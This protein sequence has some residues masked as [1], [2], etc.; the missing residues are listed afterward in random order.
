MTK[1]IYI[2]IFTCL[3][4]VLP[5]S[6]FA[7]ATD[8]WK[9]YMAYSN[10]Q[11]IEKGGNMLYVLASNDLYSYNEKD[12]SIQTFDKVNGLNDTDIEFIAWNN[13]A[14]CL[15]IA[16]SDQN[17]DLLT[18]KGE[19][20]SLSD[21][22]RKTM[23]ANKKIN[24][25][26]IEGQYCYVSTGFGILKINVSKAE[27]SDTYNLGFNVNYTY[28][29]GNYI[30]AASNEQGLFRALLSDN[31]LDRNNWQW[32]G[33]YVAQNK[34]I[35]P[36]LLEKV[37]GLQPGGPKYNRF[38]FMQYLNNRLY[39]TGGAFEPGAIG[40]NQPGT[41][42]VLK[43]G[44]WDI[45]QDELDKITGYYYH[46]MNCLAVDPKNPEHVFA[47]GRAGL[48]EFLNGKLK[49]YFNKDNSLLRPSV[50]KGI[51]LGNDYVVI[52][53][54]VFDRKNN[55]WILNSGTKTTSLLKLSP[56]GTMT[57]YSKPQLMN[58]GLSLHVM[59]RPI[60]DSRG[61]IW[62][63]NSHYEAPGLFC[64]N[65][66]TDK[67]NVY[68]NFKNQ[69]GS[70]IMVIQ[71]R[72]V[73]EDAYQNIW[74]GTN[75]G[76]L[77]LTTEQMK[78]P[79][80][81]IFEQIKIPRNDGTN[82]ADY[83]LAGVDISC[84][85]IDGGGRKWFGTNGNGV[86]LISADNMKQVQH[87]LSDNSKLISN[88]I[89]SI[90]INDKTGEVFI[91]TDKGLC[92]YM[93][94]ATKPSDNPGGEETYAY[95]NPVRPNY[96]GLITVVGL[97]FNSDVKIVTTNGVLVAKGT[98]NGGTF[99]WDGNDLNGKRVASGVYMVQTSDQEGNNGTVCKI[100]IVN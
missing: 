26:Y 78:N 41:I 17:I 27:I 71:M 99:T 59:R 95:P 70:S 90:A 97:A 83:L 47:G 30:Y 96:T 49:R 94:D 89:E 23:T 67:L 6:C 72:C 44:E 64:Y 20:I 16:Y 50:H 66:E 55:L 31:L 77:R 82:L 46:D 68:N 9:N 85:A 54:L 4:F 43:N 28:I 91:G 29:E 58:K 18:Q 52:Q 38:F 62:F 21:Y 10:V 34:T 80:E 24:N 88:N 36:E 79:S 53:G 3:L 11:W 74:I 7:N 35:A 2:L 45:Y 33:N 48:Y 40:L 37:K 75:V 63:V 93:S 87:F 22:Y 73:V 13:V 100:A 81:A 60:L 86:Y 98:S 69:D 76:P 1:R 92:S 39:T 42:Q 25:L 65:P 57:D 84:M 32:V 19:I 51:E 56:D 61:L 12:N 8:T 5:L 14:K 15:V